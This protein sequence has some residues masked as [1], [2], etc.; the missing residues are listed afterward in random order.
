MAHI[1][2]LFEFAKDEEKAQQARHKLETWKQAFRLDKKLIYKLER[3]P[4]AAIT[5]TSDDEDAKPAKAKGKGN[6][7]AKAGTVTETEAAPAS[8]EDIR[9][10]V[11][12]GFSGHEKLSEQRWVDRIPTE[13][14][15]R[16]ASPV[17]VK[18]GEVKFA[19]TEKQFE[20]LA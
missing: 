13:E 17:V 18:P 2:M 10:I 12:L 20:D 11:R 6:P 1:Y 7:A 14:P 16:E 9:L 15:F 8:N 5:V 4:V 3:T 19:D